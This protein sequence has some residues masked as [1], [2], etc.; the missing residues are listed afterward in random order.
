MAKFSGPNKKKIEN[1]KVALRAIRNNLNK[2]GIHSSLTNVRIHFPDKMDF[3]EKWLTTK[4]LEE[5]GVYGNR[6]S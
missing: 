4:D 2:R 5:F 1:A 6:W 3:I